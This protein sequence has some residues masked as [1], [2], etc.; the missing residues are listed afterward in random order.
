MNATNLTQQLEKRSN[1][2]HLYGD[3]FWWGVL[4]GSSI[5]FLSIF[6]TRLGASGLQVSLLT[7]GPALVN[8]LFSL[9]AGRWLAGQPFL[10]SVFLSSIWHRIGYL[11][12]VPLP[13]FF[14][15]EITISTILWISVLMSIPGTVLA[16]SFNAA[17]AEV[18]PP[19][20]RALVVGRR[21]AVVALSMV[22]TSLICGQILVWLAFPWNY[23]VVFFIGALGAAASTYHL[24]RLKLG[25]QT[26]RVYANRP[27]LEISRP[28]IQRFMDGVRHPAGLRF[29]TRARTRS[30][31]D[32]KPLHG[33]F[34]TFLL[35][36]LAFYTFQYMAIPLFP[37]FQVRELQLTDAT[38]SLGA[39]LF[40]LMMLLTSLVLPQITA[41]L[42]HKG[43]LLV[44][45]FLFS[46]YPLLNAFAQDI[47]LYLVASI[48]G[49]VTWAFANGGLINRLMERVP[50]DELPSHMA[51][52]NLVLNLGIILGSLC[53]PFLAE[54]LGL[55]EA[56]LAAGGLRLVG[57][58]LLA[59]WA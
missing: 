50:E 44:G 52:H 39:A 31:L 47:R 29:L 41:R 22:S 10:R 8:L 6:I 16:I 21:N 25:T 35:A 14:S 55:R 32:L 5:S 30:L 24:G 56:L 18:V 51:L 20:D 58:I 36:Y 26:A 19:A 9:P 46:I 45:A 28:G 43:V 40:Y 37:L 53:S 11:L 1:F 12:L 33:A 49:G 54:M 57:A 17:F 7:A 23:A 38:I 15:P 3:V 27:L 34:G 13:L 2:W 4:A 48:L 42:G 59:I